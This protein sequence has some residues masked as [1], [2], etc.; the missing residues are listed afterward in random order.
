MQLVQ[1]RFVT[2]DVA[3]L[4]GFYARLVGVETALNDYYMEVPT[5][6]ASVGF[7]KCRFT[8][9]TDSS[10]KARAPVPVSGEV[11]LDFKVEDVDEEFIRIDRLGVAWVMKPTNQPWGA[12]AM[13]FRDPQ[14]NLVNVFSPLEGAGT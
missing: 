6:G 4:A 11:I 12:R 8:E 1:S 9:F 10:D 7:S 5:G 2:D 14:G 13:T 3:A